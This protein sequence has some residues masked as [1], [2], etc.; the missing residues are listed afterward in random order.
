MPLAKEGPDTRLP[1]DGHGAE[2]R[3]RQLWWK[4]GTGYSWPERGR[5]ELSP[6]LSAGTLLKREEETLGLG[7][8]EWG[9]S[10]KC[11]LPI[12]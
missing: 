12:Q 2:R 10:I 1:P 9:H 3:H 7:V 5:A 8:R 11:S 4:G 6:G